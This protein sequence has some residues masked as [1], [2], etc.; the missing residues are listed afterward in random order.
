MGD[1]R[2]VPGIRIDGNEPFYESLH[3]S[4]AVIAYS[5]RG[6]P[7]LLLELLDGETFVRPSERILSERRF[8]SETKVHA[9]SPC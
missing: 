8:R 3:S 4:N 9:P 5:E 1:L 6:V 7:I 2:L